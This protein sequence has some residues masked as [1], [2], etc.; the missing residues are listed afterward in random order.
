[1]HTLLKANLVL[2]NVYHKV[3]HGAYYALH[4]TAQFFFLKKFNMVHLSV[5]LVFS[6]GLDFLTVN[7]TPWPRIFFFLNSVA[8]LHSLL[9]EELAALKL[10]MTDP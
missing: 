3:G 2:F 5:G 4:G 10:S 8:A 9:T 1:M 7:V 6:L